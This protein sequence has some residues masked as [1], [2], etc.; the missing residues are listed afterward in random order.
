M[1]QVAKPTGF[2]GKLLAR[3]MAWG[4]R[5]FYRNTAKV[6]S[7]TPDDIY[8]EIGFGSGFFIKNHA[9]YA[10]R[11]AGL[12]YS[13]D[14]VKMASSIN[15]ELVKSGKA[16]FIQGKVSTLPW[17]DN[18]FSAVA[19]IETFFFWPKPQEALREIFRVL[20]PGGRLVLEMAYNKDDGK[21]HTKTIEKHRLKLYS[22]EEMKT[23]LKKTGFSEISIEY[24][25]SLWIPFKGH[26][27]PK[28]MIVKAIK[29]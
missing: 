12:D 22:G 4:H 17:K 2:F 8:L 25:K 29:A 21:D 15:E 14:M 24:Y 23:L 7:L 19:G 26:V 10:K 1:S 27:V 18:E 3:G 5:D 16:E 13:E 9:S 11:I 20:V 28:G 6:L